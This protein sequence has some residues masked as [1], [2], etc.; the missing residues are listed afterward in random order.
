M[1]TYLRKIK[2]TFVRRKPKLIT[3]VYFDGESITTADG[4]S[5]WETREHA[6]ISLQ[7][8]LAV[9]SHLIGFDSSMAYSVLREL[10]RDLVVEYLNVYSHD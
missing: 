8:H 5:S 3:K 7:N 2:H 4:K 9:N 6:E 10:E 1:N